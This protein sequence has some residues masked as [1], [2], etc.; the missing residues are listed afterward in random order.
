[1]A[2]MMLLELS[3]PVFMYKRLPDKCPG[4]AL[5]L[6]RWS[7]ATTRNLKCDYT[8]Q[9]T[10]KRYVSSQFTGGLNEHDSGN[11]FHSGKM[12]WGEG[13]W[14]G[15]KALTWNAEGLRFTPQHLQWKGSHRNDVKGLCLKPWRTAATQNK[16]LW[17]G[18]RQLYVFKSAYKLQ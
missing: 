15:D 6:R 7:W 14:L 16:R 4:P 2:K 1:M 5:N 11:P 12:A 8:S 18:I 3:V 9:S 13:M 10:L 17:L